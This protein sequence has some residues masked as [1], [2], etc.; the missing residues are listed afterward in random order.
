MSGTKDINYNAFAG[1][2]SSD[3]LYLNPSNWIP[4]GNALNYDDIVKISNKKGATVEDIKIEGGREDCSDAVRG[5][6]YVWKRVRFKPLGAGVL[7]VKGSIDGWVVDNC[8]LEAHGRKRD[9][10]VGQFDNYWF[11]GRKP[12]RG[13]V[14][15]D[16][17]SETGKPIRVLLW[18]AED[19]IVRNSNV[20]VKR[21]P[22]FIWLPYFLFRY[23]MVR[24]QGLKTG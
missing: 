11:P 7:T 10:E 20:K 23:V 6:N 3:V 21:I 18:D 4:P 16:T 5:A 2:E 17:Q 9:I 24:I 19:P 8:T 13:G 15:I 1:Q 14:I 12:T 22:T